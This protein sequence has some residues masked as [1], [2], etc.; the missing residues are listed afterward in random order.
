MKTHTSIAD[1]EA[2]DRPRE[3]MARVGIRRLRDAEVLALV[4]GSGTREASSL[5]LGRLIL[6]K[7]GGPAGLLAVDAE[8]LRQIPGVGAALAARLAGAIE[9]ARRASVRTG[10]A[11][12]PAP[13]S[14]AADAC[15]GP[16]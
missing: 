15:P 5:E 10:A 3:K 4:I 14:A 9:L 8:A 6:K 13:G 1:M 16:G 11:T 2:T 7:T 12:Q